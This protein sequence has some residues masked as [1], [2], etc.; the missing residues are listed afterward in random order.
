MAEEIRLVLRVENGDDCHRNGFAV[1]ADDVPAGTETGMRKYGMDTGDGLRVGG[2]IVF[3]AIF[4][5]DGV[6]AVEL[7]GFKW[8]VGTR[9][10]YAVAHPEEIANVN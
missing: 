7:H 4:L 5:R 3:A 9:L 10:P 1:L 8:I 2:G 6:E